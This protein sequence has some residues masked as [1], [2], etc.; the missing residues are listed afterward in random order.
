VGL[1][2]V[3]VSGLPVVPLG[4]WLVQIS[5][6][7]SKKAKTISLI[8]TALIFAL[9]EPLLGLHLCLGSGLVHGDN[10]LSIAMEWQQTIN[11]RASLI[12]TLSFFMLSVNRVWTCFTGFLVRLRS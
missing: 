7:E 12:F 6:L 2:L 1:V 4:M 10:L 3:K 5:P 8:L 11:R 9:W